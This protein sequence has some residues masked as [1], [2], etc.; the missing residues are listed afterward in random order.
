MVRRTLRPRRAGL[1]ATRGDAPRDLTPELSVR[2]RVGYGGGDFS[3]AG[4][5]VYFVEAGG[6]VY[7]QPLTTGPATPITPGFGSAAAPTVSPDQRWVV[8][9]HTYEARCPGHCGC[10]GALMAPATGQRSGFLHAA[11]LAS[12]RYPAGLGRVEPSADALGG[13]TPAPG[14]SAL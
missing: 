8:F 13:L 4:G 5:Y 6:R 1:P 14:H 2:A 11:V 12:A 7:R 9:V 10:R 3:V